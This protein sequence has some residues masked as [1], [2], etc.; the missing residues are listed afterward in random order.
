MN[1][2]VEFMTY[3][4]GVEYL[5]AIAFLLCFFIFWQIV[6][7]RGRGLFIKVAP[8]AVGILGIGALASTCVM[9]QTGKTS[10]GTLTSED[11]LLASPVLTEI[12]GPA[13]FDHP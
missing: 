2:I 7:H 5:I 11:T 3:T 1:T 10:A 6:H 12:Y 13:S 8:L 4:K 9:Q